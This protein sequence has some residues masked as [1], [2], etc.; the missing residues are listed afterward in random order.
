MFS[1]MFTSMFASMFTS[2][3]KRAFAIMSCVTLVWAGL[4]PT[5]KIALQSIPPFTFSATRLVIGSLLLYGYMRRK[6]SSATTHIPWTPQLIG[7]FLIL[8]FCGYLISV[9]GSYLGLRLTTATNAALLNA[10]SPVIIAILA[11]L[12][13]K[14]RL[15]RRT[16]LGIGLSVIGVGVIVARG[17]WQVILHSQYNTGDLLILGSLCGWGTYTTYGRH[18]M[19]TISPLVATTYAYIAGAFFVVLV[20]L[21]TE[22]GLWQP[23]D[24]PLPAWLAL[25]YQSTLGTLAHFWFYDAVAVLG[26]SRA[27]IF[28]NLVPVMAIGIA[29]VLLN[30]VL[31]IAHLVGGAIVM[32][33]VAIATRGQ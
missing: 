12:F 11:A 24:T 18:I 1:S 26:S 23:T 30:E 8:G 3:E 20:S 6:H 31:T 16:I 19:H 21:S 27:G 4:F 13:L 25:A 28:I 9:S 15:S 10:A 33:G 14:E 17:S 32:G 5:G 7:S 2:K 29:S 22:W